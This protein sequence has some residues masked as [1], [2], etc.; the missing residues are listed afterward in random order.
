MPQ[1]RGNEPILGLNIDSY[2]CSMTLESLLSTLIQGPNP[3]LVD[4]P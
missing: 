1:L 2:L 3:K 4:E